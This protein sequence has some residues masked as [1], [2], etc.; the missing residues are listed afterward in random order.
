MK[1]V[2]VSFGVLIAVILVWGILRDRRRFARLQET[3]ASYAA[4]RGDRFEASQG[5]AGVSGRSSPRI[6]GIRADVPFELACVGG[7]RTGL[8]WSRVTIPLDGSRAPNLTVEGTLSPSLLSPHVRSIYESLRSQRGQVEL[9]TWRGPTPQMPQPG[10]YLSATW[11]GLEQDPA[12]FDLAI[13]LATQLV[14][15]HYA[16][17]GARP[18]PR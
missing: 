16:A 2:L 8:R 1:V 18:A 9:Q 12:V 4:A 5:L 13:E 3:W 10:F 7:H 14:L 17:A 11:G 15:E 6:R